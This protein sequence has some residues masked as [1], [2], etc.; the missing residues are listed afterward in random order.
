MGAK[1]I[2]LNNTKV[3]SLKPKNK[4]YSI[5]DGRGLS[6]LI[7]PNGSKLWEF[8]FVCPISGKRKK[9][10]FGVYPD[11]TLSEARKK[12]DDYRHLVANGINPIEHY[13]NLKIK[14]KNNDYGLFES[15]VNAWL[16][17]RKKEL[18]PRSYQRVESLLKKDVV[19]YLKNVNMKDIKHPALAKIIEKKN[20]T[21]PESAKR[22]LQYL[23]NL[24]L[25]GISKGF[26]DFNITANIDKKSL[27][28][29]K[30]VQHYSKIVK[31][32]ILSELINAIYNYSGHY[33]T[34]NILRFVLHLPLR[35]NNL[36]NLKW[37]YIDFDKRTLTIPRAE[38]KMKDSKFDF[39]LPLT[40]E[41]I[42]IL[43]EQKQF[44]SNKRYIFVSDYG[45]HLNHETPNRVLQRMGFN[46]E[47]RGR[48][49]RLH[50]FRGTF[51]SLA[52]TYRKQN[53]A[54]FEAKEAVLDHVIGNETSRAYTDLADYL[55]QTRELLEW[56]SEFIVEMIDEE[57]T[58]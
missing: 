8:N 11:I 46:D 37:E 27:I 55:E 6:L 38:M 9:T 13:R 7:K 57:I 56:W 33:S 34:G 43:Q 18:V 25:Y 3:K 22:L 35:A 20:A 53:N 4:P 15:V 5:G 49:Q 32:D 44:T 26:A 36:V 45:V 21:A 42:N 17:L 24:W 52:D 19:P 23:S 58:K 2:P 47:K 31:L 14:A 29:Q 1:T 16:K 28:T 51:R 12:R 41:V 50:S 54:S 39:V 48:K 30:K 10:S 40:D